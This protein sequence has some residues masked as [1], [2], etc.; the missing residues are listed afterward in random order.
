MSNAPPVRIQERRLD[1]VTVLRLEGLADDAGLM[2][3]LAMSL[4]DARVDGGHV[5]LDFDGLVVHDPAALCA[6]FA[7][8]GAATS[9]V[10]IPAAVSDPGLRRVLRACGSGTAG[11]ACFG[12]VEEAAAVAR[13]SISA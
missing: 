4:I 5:V 6:F 13:P 1:D 3:R 11:L 9:G 10:P 8:L 2:V 12:S 7:R